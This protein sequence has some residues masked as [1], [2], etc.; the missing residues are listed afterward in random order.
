MSSYIGQEVMTGQC[1]EDDDIRPESEDSTTRP[2]ASVNC[3]GYLKSCLTII[4]EIS[5]ADTIPDR[6]GS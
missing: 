5:I 1:D 4:I 3:P 6:L 2:D